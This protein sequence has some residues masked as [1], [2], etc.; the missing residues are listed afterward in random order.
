MLN[1]LLADVRA[2]RL[3]ITA[4][5]GILLLLTFLLGSIIVLV[6]M[7]NIFHLP[8]AIRIIL[9]IALLAVTAGIFFLAVIFPLRNGVTQ[10]GAALIIEK[11]HPELDNILVN[12]VTLQ[13]SNPR[14]NEFLKIIIAEAEETAGRIDPSSCVDRKPLIRS[15]KIAAIPVALIIAYAIAFPDLFWNGFE[16]IANPL[17]SVPPI[18]RT[19]IAVFPGNARVREGSTLLIEGRI[20]GEVPETCSLKVLSSGKALLFPMKFSGDRFIYE[21]QEVKN[22]FDY[23]I[24]GGDCTT[25]TFR[26]DVDLRIRITAFSATITEPAYLG[27]TTYELKPF[28]GNIE[29]VAGAEAKVSAKLNMEAKS[30]KLLVGDKEISRGKS[31]SYQFSIPV[32]GDVNY[33]I[34]LKQEGYDEPVEFGPYTIKSLV[35]NAPTVSIKEPQSGMTLFPGSPLKIALT[36]ADDFGLATV[37]LLSSKQNSTQVPMNEWKLT[38]RVRSW[39]EIHQPSAKELNLVEGDILTF[40]AVA[41]DMK[42]NSTKSTPVTVRVT[43]EAEASKAAVKE[44]QSI[45]DALKR[46]LEDQKKL[47]KETDSFLK[48]SAKTKDTEEGVNISVILKGETKIFEAAK[49]I[50]STWKGTSIADTEPR[51]LFTGLISGPINKAMDICRAHPTT[52]SAGERQKSYADIIDC[53]NQIIETLERI[54][55]ILEKLIKEIKKEGL[56]QAMKNVTPL[57]PTQ[58]L[59]DLLNGL[60]DFMNEQ[61]N[62]IAQTKDLRGINPD[63]FSDQQE[64]D[65]KTLAETEAQWGRWFEEKSTD[66]SKL[67]PQ[68]FSN[69]SVL[70]ELNEAYSAL[71][72]GSKKLQGKAIEMAIPLEESGLEL[73]SEITENIERWLADAP[74]NLKWNMEEPTQEY[75]VPMAD[76]PEELEDLIGELIDNE[77]EMG[78][79]VQDVTSSWMDSLNKG[80]GWT[81]MDGPI[82]NMSAKGITGNL[83]P[84]SNEV[85]GRSGEGRSGKSSGQMVEESATGKGGKQTPSRYTPD[86]YEKGNVKDSGKDK[87]GGSTGGGKTS[88][89]NKE[90]IRGVPPPEIRQKMERL[91]GNQAEIL[92]QGE[93]L[94]LELQKRGYRS[95]NLEKSLELMK[96][97]ESDLKAYN[98]QGLKENYNNVINLLKN[99]QRSIMGETEVDII[100]PDMPGFVRDE[101]MNALDEKKPEEFREMLK[102]YYKSLSGQ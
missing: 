102:Q 24:E 37:R 80:A 41:V 16:R 9:S 33:K 64:K 63:D 91:A 40:V 26:I 99:F 68:D 12:A 48:A 29:A 55:S 38:G 67:P 45:L 79:D 90:G 20:S 3:M 78:E 84:N 92:N 70:Q 65:V 73:A 95:Q 71:A 11:A 53:Q 47:K 43:S 44:A 83:Q 8:Q 72:E 60:K 94:K 88:G 30:A 22:P 5:T 1:K 31:D 51:R 96:K 14:S 75:D 17:A 27:Q 28:S 56:V 13:K 52:G 18:T 32:D 2:K 23:S 10:L 57:D 101:L 86:P 93:K 4:S 81:A 66:L 59:K 42:G 34:V 58:K 74:D 82:S 25:D 7:D 85:G 62:V 6:G 100:N 35:D 39:K 19:M 69:S 49:L 46:L 54:L 61:K 87:A 97:M 36:A 50:N 77:E 89:T 21:F 76:L 98:P 15:T